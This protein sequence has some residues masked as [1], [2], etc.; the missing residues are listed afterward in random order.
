MCRKT[1]LYEA[2]AKNTKEVYPEICKQLWYPVGDSLFRFLYFHDAHF[3]SGETDAPI[4]FPSNMEEFKQRMLKLL[5]SKR[6][7]IQATSPSYKAG[8]PAL[9][10]LACRH[11]RTPVPPFLWFQLAKG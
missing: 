8:L 10:I 9:D 2:V 7:N 11:F 3:D 5:E 1:P 6:H 4:T